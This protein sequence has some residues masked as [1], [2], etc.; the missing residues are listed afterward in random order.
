MS[1][2]GPATSSAVMTYGPV[3]NVSGCAVAIELDAMAARAVV[4]RAASSVSVRMG[5]TGIGRIGGMYALR[6][7]ISASDHHQ[8]V[9]HCQHHVYDA[10]IGLH[11]VIQCADAGR[12]ARLRFLFR[13]RVPYDSA[14]P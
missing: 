12:C 6:G 14:A 2:Y 3:V 5:L 11:D 10:V 4:A 13:L 9:A 8:A 1:R 7:G